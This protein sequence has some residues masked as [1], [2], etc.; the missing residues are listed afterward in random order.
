LTVYE[1]VSNIEVL[2]GDLDPAKWS[3]VCSIDSAE[4]IELYTYES[5]ISKY[6]YYSP[7]A[8]S[9]SSGKI[10]LFDSDCGNL[11]CMFLAI[12]NVPA[13]QIALNPPEV[14]SWKRVV[15]VENG[16]PDKCIKSASCDQVSLSDGFSDLICLPD[17]GTNL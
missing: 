15:C 6:P 2:P 14:S 12:A 5:L 9:Y 1:A 3:E 11:T 8:S 7:D 17:K 4:Q 16:K 13:D 10:V